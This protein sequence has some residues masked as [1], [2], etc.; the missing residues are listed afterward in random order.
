MSENSVVD[1]DGASQKK[2]GEYVSTYCDNMR[3]A[4]KAMIAHVDDAS[5]NIT[6]PSAKPALDSLKEFAEAAREGGL[7]F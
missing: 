2:F 3:A 7:K 5:D 6:D 1:R 4:C